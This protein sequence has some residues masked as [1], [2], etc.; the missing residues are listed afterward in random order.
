MKKWHRGMKI[1]YRQCEKMEQ[2]KYSERI[3]CDKADTQALRLVGLTW[4]RQAR[5]IDIVGM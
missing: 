5:A 1:I 3:L 2:K 4:I